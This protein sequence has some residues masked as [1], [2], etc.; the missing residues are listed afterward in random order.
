MVPKTR[1]S[2]LV[3]N[4]A[5]KALYTAPSAGSAAESF[6]YD[7]LLKTKGAKLNPTNLNVLYNTDSAL[8]VILAVPSTLVFLILGIPKILETCNGSFKRIDFCKVTLPL[9]KC[10]INQFLLLVFL[11]E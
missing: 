9:K 3:L 11:K 6:R 2:F 1:F 7:I 8:I 5:P 10:L 4:P